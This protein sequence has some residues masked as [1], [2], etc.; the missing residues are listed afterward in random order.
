SSAGG[1]TNHGDILAVKADGQMDLGGPVKLKSFPLADLPDATTAGA[2]SLIYVSD[3]ND[4]PAV[5]FSDGTN[6]LY[7]ANNSA[8]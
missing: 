2:G 3:G 7:V 6:W 1:F 4:G 5:A 8:V